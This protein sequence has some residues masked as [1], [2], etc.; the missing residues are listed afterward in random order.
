MLL[1]PALSEAEAIAETAELLMYAAD[2]AQHVSQL[3]QPNLAAG[4]IVLCDRFTDSTVAYQGYGRELDLSLI[5][6]LNQIATGGLTSD[7]TLWFDVDVMRGL[8]RAR[9]RKPEHAAGE[10][11]MEANDLEF[12]QRVQAGFKHLAQSNPQRI[13]RI[14]SNVSIDKVTQQVQRVLQQ[15]FEQWF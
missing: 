11:R 10:D 1:D 5:D 6:Q 3:V 12:H 15:R 13:I 2:R 7:L 14:D 8:A 9:S 4:R